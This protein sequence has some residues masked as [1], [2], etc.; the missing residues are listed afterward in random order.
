MRKFWI[1]FCF[2]AADHFKKKAL[3]WLGIFFVAPIGIFFAIDQFGGGSYDNVAIVQESSNFVVP[4]SIFNLLEG[5]H[6]L[7]ITET[8]ALDKFE[9]GTLD[10]VF[11]IRGEERPVIDI[12][13]THL[14]P[15]SEVMMILTQTL[16]HLH[17]EYIT[18]QYDLPSYLINELITPIEVN[19]ETADLEDLIAVELVGLILPFIIYMVVLLTGQMLSNSVASEKTSRV[20]EVMLGK[21]HPTISLVSKVLA[22]L[23]GFLMAPIAIIAGVVIAHFTGFTDLGMILEIINEFLSIEALLLSLVMIILGFFS[24]IFLFAAAGAIANSVESLTSTLQ[25]LIYATMI[26]F[27]AIM[28]IDFDST[29]AN[30]LVYI[31]IFSPYILV[32]RYILRVSS[33][34]E[35]GVVIILLSIFSLLTLWISSRLYMNGI[36]HNS[37]KIGIKDLKK[38]L[39]K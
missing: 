32:Q 21:V 36:S 4:P 16:T 35:V 12:K 23:V 1:T 17:L 29:I 24:F 18:N 26:P 22:T 34:L 37:E 2:Y 10:D 33:I 39:V 6:F 38:M 9:N 14:N 3:I 27:F 13:S 28:F 15:P 30:I 5:R 31:P 8:E 19:F 11:V 25:P 7:F 20:M